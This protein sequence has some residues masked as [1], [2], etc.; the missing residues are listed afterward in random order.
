MARRK[1]T[2]TFDDLIELASTFVSALRRHQR[3]ALAGNLAS[4][5]KSDAPQGM[6]WREVE[7]LDGDALFELMRAGRRDAGAAF[8]TG[9]LREEPVATTEVTV[10]APVCPQCLGPMVRRVANNGAGA[11]EAFWGCAVFPRCWGTM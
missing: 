10:T 4:A 7:M 8:Q 5:P 1:K 11:G 6:S 9:R 2:G 3:K